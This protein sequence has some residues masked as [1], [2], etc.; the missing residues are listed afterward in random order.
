MTE[1]CDKLSGPRR[2]SVNKLVMPCSL[3]Y[4]GWSSW[5]LT[6]TASSGNARGNGAIYGHA[7]GFVAFAP[8]GSGGCHA[9]RSSEPYTL[10]KEGGRC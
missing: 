3:R 1:E 6:V 5:F 2:V 8:S 10:L 7:S 9:S 4:V